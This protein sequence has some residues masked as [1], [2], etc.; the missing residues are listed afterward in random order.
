MSSVLEQASASPSASSD[1]SPVLVESP[2]CQELRSRLVETEED[3]S[4]DG[5]TDVLEEKEKKTTRRSSRR[6]QTELDIASP[7]ISAGHEDASGASLSSSLR[8]S[9][10]TRHNK[11]KRF[12]EA[13]YNDVFMNSHS[14]Y[15]A[16]TSE[17]AMNSK[18]RRR[19]LDW[20]RS[21]RAKRQRRR[22]GEEKE[23]D[24]DD[25]DDDEEHEEEA[26]H[27]DQ[28]MSIREINKKD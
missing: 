5:D 12:D 22:A 2:E 6:L 10:R 11:P 3:E 1:S 13:I 23:E 25:E 21:C 19:H 17:R 27:L 26:N 28:E 18:K 16:S 8:Y 7:P 14:T 20:N 15:G 9:L 24:E 4:E